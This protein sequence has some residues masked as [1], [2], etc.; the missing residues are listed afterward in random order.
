MRKEERLFFSSHFFKNCL[1]SHVLCALF[2]ACAGGAV[3]PLLA[4]VLTGVKIV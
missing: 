1:F 2:R 3:A 4:V